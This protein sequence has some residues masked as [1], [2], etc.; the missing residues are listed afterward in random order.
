MDIAQQALH[1][2][3]FT[4]LSHAWLKEASH[5]LST[6]NRS[7]LQTQIEELLGEVRARA[8]NETLINTVDQDDFDEHPV[9]SR[10][11][12]VFSVIIWYFLQPLPED[13]SKLNEFDDYRFTCS[14][15]IRLTPAEQSHLRCGYLTE[16]H[17]FLL[18]APLKVEELSHD[19]LLLLYHEVIYQSEIDIIADLTRNKIV[20]AT[21]TGKN[22]SEVSNARTSQFSFM[23]KTRHKVLQT[24]DERVAD[25]TDLNMR[26]CFWIR[27]L[28]PIEVKLV[29]LQSTQKIISLPTTAL[30]GIMPSTRTGSN[31]EPWVINYPKMCKL[32]Y[33]VY[34]LLLYLPDREQS[35]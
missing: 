7:E 14:G 23:P 3:G 18:L 13:Y 2:N 5:R 12:F 1:R 27:V 26:K 31:Q 17:P 25:M 11:H 29:V 22:S 21:V 4:R 33:I 28:C 10:V 19:P 35:D 15:H 6:E 30:V 20:R 32:F 16:T 34:N 24:I 8:V 9:S